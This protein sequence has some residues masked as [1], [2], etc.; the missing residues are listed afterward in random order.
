[1]QRRRDA[2]D[3]ER[4]SD[5]L[6]RLFAARG[7]GRLQADSEL[8][9]LWKSVAGHQVA[10]ETRVLG[11]KNG[12]LSIGVNSSPLLSELSAFHK[13]HLL[14]ALQQ[15]RGQAIRDLRFRRSPRVK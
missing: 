10:A 13:E 8:Q 3:P 6:G 15:R 9:E 2:S 7:Y 12:V 11:L 5:V 1:M 4:L 14:I